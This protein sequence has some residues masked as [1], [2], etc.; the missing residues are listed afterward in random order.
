MK[1]KLQV[2][3]IIVSCVLKCN[4][5]IACDCQGVADLPILPNS[6]PSFVSKTVSFPEGCISYVYS[7]YAHHDLL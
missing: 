6:V 2:T 5:D 7:P 1:G 4:V 3:P